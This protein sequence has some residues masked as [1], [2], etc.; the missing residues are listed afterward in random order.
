MYI[1][2]ET[3]KIIFDFN[4]YLKLQIIGPE[5]FYYV[6]LR[7]YLKNSTESK[8]LE[9]YEISDRLGCM[10]VFECYIEFKCDFE[11]SIYKF[12]DNHGLKRI[13][14]H[15][16]SEY[17][18]NVRFNLHSKDENECNIWSQRIKKYKD[19]NECN[20]SINSYFDYLD[21]LSDIDFDENTEF[22]KTYN[23]GRFPKMSTDFRSNDERMEG[24]VWLGN[25]KKFWSYQHPRLWR[26]LSSQQIVDD[27]LALS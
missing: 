23:I 27:I 24:L 1:N 12:L 3:E 26:N 13:F 21:N 5:R 17:R 10:N 20:I 16:F 11:I 25:W 4:P 19:M 2:L 14:T 22:Y 15:R 18:Q 7:E 9:G 8:F 6:E